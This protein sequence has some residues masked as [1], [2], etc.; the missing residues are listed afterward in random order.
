M[1][2]KSN[3]LQNTD[4]FLIFSLINLIPFYAGW[5]KDSKAWGAAQSESYY[6]NEERENSYQEERMTMVSVSLEYAMTVV[7]VRLLI[8]FFYYWLHLENLEQYNKRKTNKQK[9]IIFMLYF[10][11]ICIT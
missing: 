3:K 7:S 4:N 5:G 10:I 6:W 9:R 8:I 1:K 2:T 11:N